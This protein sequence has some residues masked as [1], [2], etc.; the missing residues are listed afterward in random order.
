VRP[1]PEELVNSASPELAL[2]FVRSR[3]NQPDPAFPRLPGIIPERTTS[4]LLS[5]VRSVLSM[6]CEHH[7][8]FHFSN[9][10]LICTACS[11]NR[12][13]GQRVDN[14]NHPDESMFFH[15]AKRNYSQPF[16]A[17]N[18]CGEQ[19]L[20]VTF[21][22]NP[23]RQKFSLLQIPLARPLIVNQ[24]TARNFRAAL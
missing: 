13:C 9:N 17:K 8:N 23:T 7:I 22:K 19:V 24:K 15:F 5:A 6:N 4:I 2:R 3:V 11:P 16:Q 10:E 1:S 20:F 21:Q 14:A 18:A 12:T